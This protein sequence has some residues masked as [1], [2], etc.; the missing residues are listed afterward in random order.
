VLGVQ[1]YKVLKTGKWYDLITWMFRDLVHYAILRKEDKLKIETFTPSPKLNGWALRAQAIEKFEAYEKD[2]ISLPKM[3][4]N[5]INSIDELMPHHILVTINEAKKQF[6]FRK[7]L[8][9]TP[10]M[11]YWIRH[12]GFDFCSTYK[13]LQREF[14]RGLLRVVNRESL[15][16][17]IKFPD[18]KL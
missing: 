15:P 13:D 3:F 14:D 10:N 17:P 6:E 5:A 1:N 7:I 4:P 11:C 12:D 18:E 8:E 2:G 9:L 16:Q